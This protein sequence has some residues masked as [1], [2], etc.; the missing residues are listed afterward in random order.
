MFD[1]VCGASDRNDTLQ[2]KMNVSVILSHY[3]P[4]FLLNKREKWRERDYIKILPIFSVLGGRQISNEAFRRR[5]DKEEINHKNVEQ[6]R[7]SE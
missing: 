1:F 4:F 3:F 5:A 6:S 7:L 2:N